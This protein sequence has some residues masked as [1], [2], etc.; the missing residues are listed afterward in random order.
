M[1]HYIIN[2][3]LTDIT[4]LS[5]LTP[6]PENHSHLLCWLGEGLNSHNNLRSLLFRK[7]CAHLTWQEKKILF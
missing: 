2:D 3:N 1:E 6:H 7:L 4:Y 5:E